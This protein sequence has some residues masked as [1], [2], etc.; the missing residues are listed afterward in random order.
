MLKNNYLFYSDYL[1]N[2]DINA[3]EVLLAKTHDSYL[4]G[5]IINSNF[6][7]KS[8][9]KRIKSSSIYNNKIYKK[10]SKRKS[11]FLINKYKNRLSD[12]EVMEIFRDGKTI[13]HTI[14]KVPGE[15]K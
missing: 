5:P 15:N 7:E 3:K 2:K 10:M 12:N 4:I 11:D 6:N 8:F 1:R 14:L 9:Y 13:F